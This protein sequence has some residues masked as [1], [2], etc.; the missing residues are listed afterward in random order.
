MQVNDYSQWKVYVFRT[1]C[2]SNR[3]WWWILRKFDTLRCNY[4]TVASIRFPL[5]LLSWSGVKLTFTSSFCQTV[6]NQGNVTDWLAGWLQHAMQWNQWPIVHTFSSV[7]FSSCLQ[8]SGKL[9]FLRICGGCLKEWYFT[10]F[11]LN[12]RV[13]TEFYHFIIFTQTF[14]HNFNK[15]ETIEP[16][17]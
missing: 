5:S 9:T 13:V 7:F 17:L 3:C 6:W 14:L 2:L 15:K 8:S 4:Q 1:A 16:N 12:R 10:S 11:V